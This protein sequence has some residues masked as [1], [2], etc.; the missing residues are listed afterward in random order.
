MSEEFKVYVGI[1]WATTAHEVCVCAGEDGTVIE[2]RSVAHSGAGLREMTE[3][4]TQLGEGRAEAVAV[5]IEVPHGAVVD[6]LLDRGIAVFSLNPKQLDRFR[7]RF[8]PS[9]AKD[10][11]RDARALADALRT[12][13]RAF[14]RLSAAPASTVLLRELVRTEDELKE[15][16][17]RLSNRLRELLNRYY[18][19]VLTLSPAADDSWVWELLLKAP[20]PAQGRVV[21]RAYLDQLL[22]RHRIRR[23]DSAK[24]M[25]ALEA[26][27]LVVAPGVVEAA[28][29]HVA[30]L[31]PRLQLI[32][33]QLK[34]VSKSLTEVLDALA[35]P[36]PDESDPEGREHRDVEILLS[37]PGV[38]RITVAT[39][40]A[41]ASWA[42]EERD[43]HAFRSQAGLAPVTKSSGKSHR[44]VMRTA[45][46]RRLRTAVYHMARVATIH[47]PAS[48]DYYREL[49]GR[50]KT[51]GC[52]LRSVADRLCGILFAMLRDRTVYNP[53][54]GRR[55]AAAHS[56]TDTVAVTSD[57]AQV[58]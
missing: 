41:Q 18:P 27:P 14:R 55:A 10:D 15:E 5:A 6:A 53:Q 54:L 52:A 37:G 1:D 32:A 8:G 28:S 9:G 17:R 31:V 39:M 11:R 2:R 3:W 35:E 12:D 21:R 48:R 42:I 51:H 23:L 56:C 4:L 44:V 40:L 36:V 34:Q 19:Q 13:R 22:R 47:D 29:G 26:T 16:S 30:I 25:E 43:Y 49:R 57:L 24:I 7:D 20:T 58:A 46:D 38:G 33:A 50:G 45:C